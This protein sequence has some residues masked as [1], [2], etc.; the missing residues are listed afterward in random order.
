M[1]REIDTLI[2]R[3]RDVVEGEPWYGDSAVRKLDGLEIQEATASPGSLERSVSQLVA[4]MTAYHN[5]LLAKIAGDTGYKLV[6]DSEDDWRPLEKVADWEKVYRGFRDTYARIVEE[7]AQRHDSWLDT[8]VPG[9]EYSFRFLINGLIEHNVY[10]TGQIGIILR[11]MRS[12]GD[13]SKS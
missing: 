13:G 4:H 2:T 8:S 6:V 7:L 10:H 1:R 12:S 9:R 11:L 5:Y 3:F